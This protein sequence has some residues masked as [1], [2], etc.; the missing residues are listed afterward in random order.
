MLTHR[1]TFVLIFLSSLTTLACQP[2]TLD[3]G[4]ESETGD[5]SGDGDGDG[6]GDSGDGAPSTDSGDSGDPT[7]NCDPSEDMPCPEGQKCTVLTSGGGA[8]LYDCVPDDTAKLP[9]ESCTPAPGTGQDQCP[10]GYACIPSEPDS[11]TGL[12]LELCGDDDD[13][14]AALCSAPLDLQIPVC[15]AVCD[16][17]APLCPELQVCQRVRASNFVCRYPRANDQGSTAD[18]CS[19]V[20]DSGC[21]EGFVCETGGIIPGCTD[22][23]CCTALCDLADADPCQAPMVCGPIPLDPQPGLEN[24]GACYVPQ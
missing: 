16:P 12:C 1:S 10:A 2:T 13:C 19:V 11:P 7:F 8:P 4:S 17:L 24:V 21:A 9:F 3:D 18:P 22:P 20:N 6:D 5:P 23:S 14:D 15:A